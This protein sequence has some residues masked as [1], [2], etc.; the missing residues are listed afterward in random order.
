VTSS[1]V[2]TPDVTTMEIPTLH[3]ARLV[4]RGFVADDIDTFT[5]ICADP[6]VMRYIG[7][8]TVADAGMTWRAMAQ[9]L[10]HW[11]LRGYGP[12]A[13]TLA[14]DGTLLGR[15]GLFQ[16]AGW[17]GLEIGWLLGRQHW[18]Q[19]YAKEAA[20]A[21]LEWAREHVRAT[22]GYCS[23]IHPDNVASRRVAE[24]LGGIASQT[25]RLAGRPVIIFRYPA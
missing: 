11:V 18:G 15:A 14:G 9:A 10:G 6:E 19:G 25:G 24:G 12:W 7:D 3:T 1:D 21:A 20:S 5:A 16:P 22:E 2:T 4:L 23:I 13:V 17:P 8:G